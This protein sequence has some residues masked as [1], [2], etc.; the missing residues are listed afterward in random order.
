MSLRQIRK[1][2]HVPAYQGA[3]VRCEGRDGTIVQAHGTF[4]GVRFDGDEFRTPV[5]PDR[6]EYLQTRQEEVTCGE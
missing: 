1:M 5:A 2:Y 4:L 6:V 3:R